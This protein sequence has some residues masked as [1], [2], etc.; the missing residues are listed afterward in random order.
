MISRG[1]AAKFA[2]ILKRK[3]R[4]IE[5]PQCKK[6]R[7]FVRYV[8]VDTGVLASE[9]YGMCDHI[10]SCGYINYPKGGLI[11]SE[12][13]KEVLPPP[14][15][16]SFTYPSVM[17]RSILDRKN[18]LFTYCASKFG[19][20]LAAYT[21]A[22]YLVGSSNYW[23]KATT[24]WFKDTNGMI[25]GGHVTV[26]N[27]ITGK[28]EPDKNTWEHSKDKNYHFAQCLFGEHLLEQYPEKTVGIVES[29]KTAVLCAMRFPDMVWIA[30]KGLLNFQPFRFEPLRDRN[31]IVYQD[32]QPD[33]FTERNIWMKDYWTKKAEAIRPMVK[34]L[35]I[36]RGLDWDQE[37]TDLADII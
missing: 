10:N 11:S 30:T 33:E 21:F 24:F 22:R 1:T 14:T 34:S 25:R 8:H 15:P 19:E 31:V 28:R 26:Y 7:C 9:E 20:V 27:P 18:H 3:E 5:C 4:K 37:G 17:I 2:Y 32:R 36:F 23:P 13:K 6:R 35:E 16:I 12:T 29:P